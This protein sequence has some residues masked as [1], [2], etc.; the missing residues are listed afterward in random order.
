M[1]PAVLILY[2]DLFVMLVGLKQ[3]IITLSNSSVTASST[4]STGTSTPPSGI[5]ND[6]DYD[7]L[8]DERPYSLVDHTD[9]SPSVACTHLL[10]SFLCT[11][12]NP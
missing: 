10:L 4:R 8:N 9:L 11:C 2:P 3:D 7:D 6:E 12:E 1:I 5:N